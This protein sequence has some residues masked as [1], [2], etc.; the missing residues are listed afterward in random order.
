MNKGRLFSVPVLGALYHSEETKRI[1]TPYAMKRLQT[2]Y[3]REA[4]LEFARDK[5]FDATWQTSKPKYVTKSDWQKIDKLQQKSN[6]ID[7][8][9]LVAFYWLKSL[10]EF[11]HHKKSK[12][13]RTIIET[14]SPELIEQK[15]QTNHQQLR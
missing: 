4:I 10:S 3:V 15:I 2:V 7:Y 1:L 13:I 6:R 8:I 12:L 14:V 5:G 11:R 9:F